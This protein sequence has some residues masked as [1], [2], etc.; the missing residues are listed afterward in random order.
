[1]LAS[2]VS[3]LQEETVAQKQKNKLTKHRK[4]QNTAQDESDGEPEP[5]S[6]KKA[7]KPTIP[8]RSSTKASTRRGRRGLY[9]LFDSP[10]AVPAIA[11]CTLTL[12]PSVI[13]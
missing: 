1:M 13:S 7:K 12:S 3:V 8:K 9:D 10:V 5:S 2:S 11:V 6:S 4:S